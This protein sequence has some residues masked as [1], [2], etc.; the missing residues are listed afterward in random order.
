M[1][2]PRLDAELLLAHVL[3]CRR[4][5][6]YLDLQHPPE[7]AELARYRELVRRRGERE[8]VAYLTGETGFWKLELKVGQG[9]L[10]PSPDTETLVEGIVEAARHLRSGEAGNGPLRMLELG[11][12]SGAIPLAVCSDLS[13]VCWVAVERS[14]AAMAVAA[15]NRRRHAALLAP[16]DNALHLVLG[17]R[18]GAIAPHWRPHLIAGN[19]P[20]IPT[21]TV[22]RLMPEVSRFEPRMALDGGRDGSDFQRYMIRHAANALIPGGRVLLEMGAEQERLLAGVVAETPGLALVGMLDDLAGHPRVLVAERVA[23]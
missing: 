11:T 20:Y 18:F 19:P 9:I 3:G 16:R 23:E 14:P 17:D 1:A 22:E 7:A 21:G 10:I 12:G 4:I 5:D 8:P 6:L 13:G 15:E 2:S